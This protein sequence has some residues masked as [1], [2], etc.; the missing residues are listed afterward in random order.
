M[1]PKGI[2]PKEWDLIAQ[3]VKAEANFTCQ[4]CHK[5]PTGTQGDHLTVHHKD[6]DITNSNPTNLIA[7]CQPCH[8]REQLKLKPYQLKKL[9]EEAGQSTLLF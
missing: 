7:L 2:Y 8:L 3:K 5:K 6:G 1:N 9:Q 4:I